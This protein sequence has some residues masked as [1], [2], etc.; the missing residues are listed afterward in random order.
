[1]QQLLWIGPLTGGTPHPT[2][3]SWCYVKYDKVDVD[4]T[5]QLIDIKCR[6]GGAETRPYSLSSSGSGNHFG[7]PDMFYDDMIAHALDQISPN[8]LSGSFPANFVYDNVS[9]IRF[10]NLDFN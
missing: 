3:C 2:W 7:V 4:R 6:G 5:I 10:S 1:M 9:Y 8:N